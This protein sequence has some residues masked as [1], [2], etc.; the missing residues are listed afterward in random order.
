ME[1]AEGMKAMTSDG[2]VLHAKVAQIL[3]ALDV[4]NNGELSVPEAKV[5]F[6][7]LLQMK[8]V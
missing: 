1:A 6:A 2:S 5:L 8:H 3:S 4:D 7:D